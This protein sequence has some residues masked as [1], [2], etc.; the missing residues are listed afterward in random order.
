MHED[1][2]SNFWG[3]IKAGEL[4]VMSHDPSELIPLPPQ[5]VLNV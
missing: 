4:T 3:P 5:A 2:Q 1:C